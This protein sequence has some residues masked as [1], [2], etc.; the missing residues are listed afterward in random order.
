MF[1]V[2]KILLF[3]VCRIF[4]RMTF[5]LGFAVLCCVMQFVISSLSITQNYFPYPRQLAFR[6]PDIKHAELGE[7]IRSVWA[8]F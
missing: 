2:T 3:I 8:V 6:T 1:I 5:V 4:L 7:L